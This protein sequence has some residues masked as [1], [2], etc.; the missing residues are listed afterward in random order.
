[1]LFSPVHAEEEASPLAALTLDLD[2]QMQFRCAGFMQ[3]QIEQY[4]DEVSGHSKPAKDSADSDDSSDEEEDA[5]NKKAKA[6]A[7]ANERGECR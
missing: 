3:A 2:E 5:T 1:M 7:K 6:A 4:L